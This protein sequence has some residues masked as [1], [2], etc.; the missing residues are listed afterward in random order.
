MRQPLLLLLLLLVLPLGSLQQEHAHGRLEAAA[1]LPAVT[2][3]LRAFWPLQEAPGDP[4]VDSVSGLLLHDDTSTGC[5]PASRVSGPG[6]F[7]P[8]AAGFDGC[9]RFLARR[10]TVPALANI[11]GPNATVTMVA[12]IS[13]HRN[14]FS[15]Y[16]AGMWRED[17]PARQYAMFLNDMH[18]HNVAGCPAPSGLVAHLSGTGGADPPPY[19]GK[20]CRSAACG[21]STNA[22]DR[23]SCVA[24]IYDGTSIAAFVNGSLDVVSGA[25]KA[26]KPAVHNPFRY[27]D[28][29]R[30]PQ[31]G[32][33][34]PPPGQGAD[35][36]VGAHIT[37]PTGGTAC[38]TG[39]LE[40]FFRGRI[41]GV[42]VYGVALSADELR[43]VC[44]M[45]STGAS[46]SNRR[47]AHVVPP[48]D[49][50]HWLAQHAPLQP[51][52]SL[53]PTPA[54]G[55]VHFPNVLTRAVIVFVG[56]PAPVDYSSNI[57]KHVS[58]SS[59]Y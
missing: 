3:G 59:R 6:M 25:D 43:R 14:N 2:R 4:K 45:D 12:W 16:I 55:S 49:F 26:G 50:T 28:P 19:H 10:E 33:F 29:P 44:A 37:C 5:R 57:Q 40:N 17:H 18:G 54:N 22:D 42:A 24:N 1:A 30:Y 46:G 38:G 56:N 52:T 23:W 51:H 21:S 58:C 32:I 7:G 11:S 9:Q 53:V 47:S 8:H 35:F 39:S 31:G 15:S 41:G 13:P 48:G 20:Y 27:P 36:D 34:H